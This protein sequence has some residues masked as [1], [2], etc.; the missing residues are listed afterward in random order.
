M[1]KKTKKFRLAEIPAWALSLMTFF[2]SLGFWQL[3]GENQ[4][5]DLS[6]TDIVIIISYVIFITAACFFIC[7]T[8]PKSVWYTPFIC[9]GLLIILALILAIVQGN[10]PSE[11]IIMCSIFVLPLTGAIVGAKIGRRKINQVK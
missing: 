3:F 5:S 8:Y 10:M 4:L 9:S 6:T 7:R 11:L 1:E 2:A